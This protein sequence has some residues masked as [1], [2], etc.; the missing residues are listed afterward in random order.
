VEGWKL[1]NNDEDEIQLLC[2]SSKVTATVINKE[3]N[4]NVYNVT[5]I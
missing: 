5:Q 4:T 2:E 1:D 3:A